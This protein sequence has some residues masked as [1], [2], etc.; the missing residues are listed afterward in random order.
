[1]T[2]RL[3]L[4]RLFALAATLSAGAAAQ[5]QAFDAVR[6]FAAP[7][8]KDGGVAGAVVLGTTEYPGSEDRRNLVLPVLDYQWASG[9]FAGTTNGLG[10]NF[11]SRSDM[12]YGLRLTADFGRK[13]KRSSALR[14]MG[15]IDAKAEAGGFFNYS[16]N[17]GLSISSSLRS[18]AGSGGDGLLADFGVNYSL[19]FAQRW[20]LGVGTDVTLANAK[21]MQSYFGVSRA[22]ATTSGYAAYTPEGGLRDV[23]TGVTLSYSF[24]PRTIVTLGL[25][26]STLLGDAAD[27]P[28]VQKKTS[29]GGLL[30]A[31]YAF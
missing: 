2:P 5:A 21:Y 11:S 13:E 17:E 31:T 25:S 19:P 8:G 18:G 6:L 9:W 30:A 27:S 16:L 15:D 22:Q 7:P 1:M 23:R 29:V 28:L 12:Q 3:P 10:Y 14:G 26:A 20:R 4:L 24:N